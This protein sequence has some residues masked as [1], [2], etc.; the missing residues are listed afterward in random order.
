MP[1]I[2]VFAARDGLFRG[3]ILASGWCT[4]VVVSG[5]RC[6]GK[7]RQQEQIGVWR[8]LHRGLHFGSGLLELFIGVGTES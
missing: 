4:F 2:A 7:L 1:A 5:G 3:L 8:G 6:A